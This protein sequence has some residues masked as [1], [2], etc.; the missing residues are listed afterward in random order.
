MNNYDAAKILG[1]SG[2]I[3]PDEVVKAFRKA[4]MKYH[5][6]RNPGGA[7]MM[8]AVNQAYQVLKEFS[9][10]L[11]H[12]AGDYGEELN[13]MINAALDIQR[14]AAG[15]IKVE[16]MGAWLWVTGDT[17]PYA[18]L[19]NR[20]TGVGFTFASKKKAWYFRPEDYRSRSRGNLSLDEIRGKYGSVKPNRANAG[21]YI[22]ARS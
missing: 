3:T 18:S 12:E 20:K 15:A 13:R 4:A 6:D 2:E 10:T 21:R 22:G 7:E 5:P 19:L 9:G 1:L 11:E 14:K 16:L 8:K 17:K